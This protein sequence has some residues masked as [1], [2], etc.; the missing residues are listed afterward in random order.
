M[1]LSGS[2]RDTWTTTRALCGN[3][4]SCVTVTPDEARSVVRPISA[5]T[6]ATSSWVSSRFFGAAGSIAGGTTN[7][8]GT[9]G[10]ANSGSV[11]TTASTATSSTSNARHTAPGP[12]S[13]AMSAPM[14]QCHTIRAP[15][16]LIAG[17]RPSVCGSCRTTT[18][19]RVTVRAAQ[20]TRPAARA[21]R[22]RSA[23]APDRRAGRGR[24]VHAAGDA[25]TWSPRRS[26]RFRR[27]RP[28]RRVD[29]ARVRAAVGTATRP[30]SGIRRQAGH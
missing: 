4:F 21:W 24:P 30:N 20:T 29:D 25:G 19:P 18:S 3:G 2:H 28:S 5:S 13:G 7:R 14:W 15:A 8:S 6:V 9:F 16:A 11:V 10:G 23:A 17:A 26:Q 12:R 27:S 1:S 22:G